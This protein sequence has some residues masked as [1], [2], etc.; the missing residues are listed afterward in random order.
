M[1]GV[2]FVSYPLPP[3]DP[4]LERVSEVLD[5]VLEPLGFATGQLGAAD[6]RAQVIFCR[7]EF[8]SNDGG[9]VDLVIDLVATPDWHITAVRYWGYPA[10]RWQLSFD[11]LGS[12]DAQLAGLT[13]TLPDELA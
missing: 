12:L 7:G 3:P 6:G 2:P 5:P 9:C 13:G 4:A 11:A 8:D 1:L 10:D